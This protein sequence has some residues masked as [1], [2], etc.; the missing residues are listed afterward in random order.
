MLGEPRLALPEG[1]EAPQPCVRAGCGEGVLADDAAREGLHV[2]ALA[3]RG[4]RQVR[5]SGAGA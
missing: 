1:G 2:P 4:S 3:P 5:V